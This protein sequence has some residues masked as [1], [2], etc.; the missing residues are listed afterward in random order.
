MLIVGGGK[1][2]NRKLSVIMP[3][4]HNVKIVAPKIIPSL[5]HIILNNKIPFIKREFQQQDLEGIGICIAATDSPDVNKKIIHD[6]DQRGILCNSVTNPDEGHFSLP[7][8]FQ[9]D[10]LMMAVSTNG[11]SPLLARK[12]RDELEKQYSKNYSNLIALL[13]KIRKKYNTM[14]PD[15]HKQ[16]FWREVIDFYLSKKGALQDFEQEIDKLARKLT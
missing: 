12:L 9:T 5:Q 11:K 14:I 10:D 6:C 1:V 15:E 2:A 4:S 13:G 3:I 7:A 16:R 8:F